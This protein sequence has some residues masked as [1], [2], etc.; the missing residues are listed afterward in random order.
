MKPGILQPDRGNDLFEVI[1]DRAVLQVFPAL[2]RKNKIERVAPCW[3]RR[4]L[5]FHLLHPLS[6]QNP[7]DAGGNC[8]NTLLPVFRLIEENISAVTI[9][10]LDLMADR[11][12]PGFQINVRPP[13]VDNL[14]LPQPGK[15]VN[16]ENPLEAVPL[17]GLQ[18]PADIIVHDGGKV[19]TLDFR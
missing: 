7:D 6:F 11:K 2:I 14:R 16:D 12:Q 13:Q 17:D 15:Q 18:E 4:Q 5:P 19:W 9:G 3:P 10:L 1:D 8:H